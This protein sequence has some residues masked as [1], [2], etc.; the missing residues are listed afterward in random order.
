[1]GYY[2]NELNE[3]GIQQTVNISGQGNQLYDFSGYINI[4][5]RE[6]S[7][8]IAILQAEDESGSVIN[9]RVALL[10]VSP[11]LEK[12]WKNFNTLFEAPEGTARIKVDIHALM[13][14]GGFF[15]DDLSLRKVI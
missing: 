14:R 6:G 2:L 4:N 10:S 8:I 9:S 15:L 12:E 13:G 7:V 5:C 11:H 3:L 1:M